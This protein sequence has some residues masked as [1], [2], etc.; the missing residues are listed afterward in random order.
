ML[1]KVERLTLLLLI[2]FLPSQLALHF[3]PSWAT[4]SGIRV[5]YLSPTL[6]F[7]DLIILALLFVSRLTIRLPLW[8]II[9]GV[10]NSLISI[11]PPVT[12]IHWF[13]LV[14]YLW[15]YNYFLYRRS[16]FINLLPTGL[17]IAVFWSSLLTWLQFLHQ[18]SLGGLWSWLGERPLSPITP[19]I[20]KIYL[21]SLG[22]LLRPYA[23]FPH[24]NAL[25]G[26]LMV[27]ALI[28]IHFSRTIKTNYWL[29]VTGIIVALATI[30]LTFSRTVI[31]L[32][33]LLFQ[34][35]LITK[36]STTQIKSTAILVSIVLLVCL[37][38]LLPGNPAS[39]SERVALI[40]KSYVVVLRSP[41]IGIGLGAFPSHQNNSL[42]TNAY[43]LNF[44]PVHSV[45]LLLAS[46]LGLPALLVAIS[47]LLNFLKP[48][49]A[50][51]QRL[52]LVAM[53]AILLAGTADH[54]WL[55]SH[56][57]LLLLTVFLTLISIQSKSGLTTN[58]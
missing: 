38:A 15:L 35:W 44:Q 4:V 10:L 48:L 32:S 34:A 58:N 53:A 17:S 57:N 14:E 46:E 11:S 21:E 52:L 8:L 5:D 13:R 39:L 18:H 40:H 22:L 3:W 47:L 33:T 56:Q 49:L 36:V 16:Y 27:S 37:I 42:T 1:L 6:Y 43:L 28:L 7:T 20:A 9:F 26:F 50:S 41:L 23:T 12:L 25:A 55:T 51:G 29:V 30:P 45:Y 54:Y 2:I 24:P 31:F 19:G